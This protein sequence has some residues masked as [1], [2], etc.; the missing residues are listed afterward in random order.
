MRMI[1]PPL[2]VFVKINMIKTERQHTVGVWKMTVMPGVG[3]LTDFTAEPMLPSLV[4]F[5][6]LGT[7]IWIEAGDPSLPSSVTL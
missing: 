3:E 5:L 7:W 6:R 4:P 2:Q 1:V